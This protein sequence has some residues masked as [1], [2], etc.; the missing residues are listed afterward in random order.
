MKH[1]EPDPAAGR[2]IRQALGYLAAQHGGDEPRAAQARLQAERWCARDAD[3]A[4]AWQ[5]AEA[6]WAMVHGMAPQLLGAL[7]LQRPNDDPAVPSRRKLLRRGAGGAALGIAGLA[8]WLGWS[9]WRQPRFEGQW[10]LARGERQGP[11]AL[12]GGGVAQLAPET[13]LDL[14]WLHSGA[15]QAVLAHGQVFFDISGDGS[16]AVQTRLGCVA[17]TDAAFSVSD[18]GFEVLVS[19][20]RGLARVRAAGE[21]LVREL[22]S[23]ERM[24]LS[25]LADGR[26]GTRRL[27]S[28]GEQIAAW[29][30]GWWSF[31]GASLADV[32]AEFSAWNGGR[33]RSAG[34]T[35]TLRLTG[36]FPV[37]RPELL[38]RAIGRALP[39]QVVAEPGGWS[40]EPRHPVR[41]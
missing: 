16:L 7:S 30:Q 26:A 10:R 35:G 28:D 15:R 3:N 5:A 41:R 2:R 18:R 24:A 8:G 39:V 12:P 17:A 14:R 20:S 19:V 38:L 13:Q 4:A 23:G 9:Q 36:S 37:D 32:A 25:A 21:E 27:P 40:I 1:A 31:T 22:R 34:N 6:R 29:R 11:R 33:L